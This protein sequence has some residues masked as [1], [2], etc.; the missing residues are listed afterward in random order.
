MYIHPGMVTTLSEKP[1]FTTTTNESQWLV[2]QFIGRV[3]DPATVYILLY[4]LIN[5]KKLCQ[6]V[7]DITVGKT[8]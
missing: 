3:N 6:A 5:G 7:E 4:S 1:D 2:T 8:V